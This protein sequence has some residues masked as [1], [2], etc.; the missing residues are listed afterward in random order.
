MSKDRLI[1]YI[2]EMSG[3]EK[4][5]FKLFISRSSKNN[6]QS[7]YAKF[8]DYLCTQSNF[9][10]SA[11]YASCNFVK[12]SQ[13]QNLKSRLYKYI[14]ESA[15]AYHSESTLDIH[16]HEQLINYHILVKKG[17]FIQA[18]R[19]LQ[20]AEQYAIENNSLVHHYEILDRQERL[21]T[22]RLK[23]KKFKSQIP[24]IRKLK[25]EVSDQLQLMTQLKQLSMQ[26][27][28]I[29]SA[30][31]RILRDKALLDVQLATFK[32]LELDFQKFPD[33]FQCVF[34]LNCEGIHIHRLRG[35]FIEAE[36]YIKPTLN[37]FELK[38]HLTEADHFNYQ[39]ALNLSITVLNTVHKFEESKNIIRLMRQAADKAKSQ[40]DKHSELILFENSSFQEIEI[41]IQQKNFTKALS[42]SKNIIVQLDQF[43]SGIHSVNQFSKY[44]RIA[45]TYFGAGKFKDAL[46]WINKILSHDELKYRKDILSSTHLLN[47]MTHYELKNY[48][49][50]PY[51]LIG[52]TNYLKKIDRWKKPEQLL[53][54]VIR[55][56]AINFNSVPRSF[57][58]YRDNLKINEKEKPL[59]K[60]AIAYF[61][62]GDWA[63]RKSAR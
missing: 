5:Y 34:S 56:V 39:Q 30:E 3:S 53:M 6:G 38:T 60:Y 31:G 25:L 57:K 13:I 10:A 59:D 23:G 49:L 20:R 4:R 50:L 37:S 48:S 12:P 46:S 61:D 42:L 15:R 40:G 41:Y 54:K 1:D 33:S 55:D 43:S 51:L 8:F 63:E 52:T 18:F 19:T 62:L 26:V 45:L 29:F 27:Y 58:N 28:T 24:Q 22:A 9:D 2:S 44:Y 16:V 17:L 32:K 21:A 36:K 35:D 47:L 11:V 7:N 14:L